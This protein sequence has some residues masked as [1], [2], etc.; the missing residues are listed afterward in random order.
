MSLVMTTVDVKRWLLRALCAAQQGFR[1][2]AW[3]KVMVDI[4]SF[5]RSD[6]TSKVRKTAASFDGQMHCMSRQCSTFFSFLNVE[7]SYC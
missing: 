1:V 3:Y 6:L 5:V 7:T 2:W 4:D